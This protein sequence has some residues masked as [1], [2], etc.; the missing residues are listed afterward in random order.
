MPHDSPCPCD[1]PGWCEEYKRRLSASQYRICTGQTS[2]LT[3]AQ[4][5]SYRELWRSLAAG[6]KPKPTKEGKPLTDDEKRSLFGDAADDPTLLGNRIAALTAAIGIPTCG[7][8]GKR[9]AWLNKAHAWLREQF[10]ADAGA[11]AV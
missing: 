4:C 2:K 8:C 1:G 6:Q 7:G 5:A 10:T 11:L 3:P 9:K